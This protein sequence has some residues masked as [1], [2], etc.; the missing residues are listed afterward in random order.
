MVATTT[1]FQQFLS[2]L[3]EPG[4]QAESPPL[5]MADALGMPLERM[6]TLAREH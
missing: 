3:E 2:C 6:A 5:K 4:S 1:A